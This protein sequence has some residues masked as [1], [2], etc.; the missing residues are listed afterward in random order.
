MLIALGFRRNP[1]Q[2][3]V[4]ILRERFPHLLDVSCN[5]SKATGADWICPAFL[6]IIIKYLNVYCACHWLR[7][8]RVLW[9]VA[10]AEKW[11]FVKRKF[12]HFFSADLGIMWNE[13]WGYQKA[14]LAFLKLT[15]NVIHPCW[16]FITCSSFW[17]INYL[18]GNIWSFFNSD[19][20]Y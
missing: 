15:L 4:L 1:I 5:F 12:F 16:N 6:G 7:P 8:K 9:H 13:C 2:Q 20:K 18:T 14:D 10:G 11:L 3:A 17:R 19:M